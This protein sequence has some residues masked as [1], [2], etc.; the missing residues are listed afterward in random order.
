M[1]NVGKKV[2]NVVKNGK[3]EQKVVKVVKSG[4]KW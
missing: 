1:V 4:K 3:H 2:V